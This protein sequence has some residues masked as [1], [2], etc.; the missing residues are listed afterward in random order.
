MFRLG[1]GSWR[2][3]R[4][5]SPL[6]LSGGTALAA[7]SSRSLAAHSPRRCWFNRPRR[8]RS[9]RRIARLLYAAQA[10]ASCVSG[11]RRADRRAEGVAGSPRRRRPRRGAG[12]GFR[13][14][15]LAGSTRASGPLLPMPGACMTVGDETTAR[16][17]TPVAWDDMGG[18]PGRVLVRRAAVVASEVTPPYARAARIPSTCVARCRHWSGYR[19]VRIRVESCLKR[20]PR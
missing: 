19:L 20:R 17:T 9:P 16:G 3:R 10:S 12:P 6:D 18:K 1:E 13:A 7:I 15:A 2:M 4:S 5:N 11:V 8:T 14:A